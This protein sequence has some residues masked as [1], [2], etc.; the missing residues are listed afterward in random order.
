MRLRRL[1]D[2]ALVEYAIEPV[3]VRLLTNDFNGIFRVDTA[4]GDRVVVRVVL[5]PTPTEK[6]FRLVKS[7]SWRE[8]ELKSR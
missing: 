4:D 7:D 3:R 8:K 1:V 2:E 6:I 5:P